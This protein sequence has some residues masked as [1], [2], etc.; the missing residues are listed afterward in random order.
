MEYSE[1]L[2][3][4]KEARSRR[5]FIESERVPAE[6]LR[7]VVDLVRYTPSGRNMQPMKY[8]I[9]TD[10][11]EC[12]SLFP[13]LAWAGYLPDWAGPESGERPAAYIVQCL[14]TSLTK[15]AMCDDGL[16]LEAITLGLVSIGLGG[17]IIKSFDKKKLCEL[18]GLEEHIVPQHVVA[19]GV[20][21]EE[22]E[23]VPMKAG[24]IKYWRDAE[25]K[26]YVPKRSIDEI[27]LN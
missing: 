7:K 20:P 21:V 10:A 24:D 9:I 1:L 22:V 6:E 2:K 11:G 5:R 14:D 19:L 15:D 16:Q 26:H 12:E 27:L 23:I 3:M 13:L 25:G 4:M 18:L 8:R 17:C